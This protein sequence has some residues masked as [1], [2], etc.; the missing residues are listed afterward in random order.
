MEVIIFSRDSLGVA[1]IPPI[2]L[3]PYLKLLYKN[4]E[5]NGINIIDLNWR[6]SF[7]KLLFMRKKIS[8]V[9][10]HWIE[11]YFTSLNPLVTFFKI[12]VFIFQ[13]LLFKILK[14]KIMVT[15]HNV[16]PHERAFPKLVQVFFAWALKLSDGIIVHNYYAKRFVVEVYE[17]NAKKIFVIPHG[18]FLN[19]YPES[20]TPPKEAKAKLGISLD[21]FVLLFFGT[22]RPYKGINL[23][24][25]SFEEAVKKNPQLFLI[26]AGDCQDASLRTELTKFQVCFPENCMFKL[27]YVPDSEVSTLMK[28][29]NIGILPYQEIT[30]SGAA[31]LFISYGL[32]LIASNLPA[33]KEILKDGSC[34]FFNRNDPKSLEKTILIAARNTT[35]YN[36]SKEK[37]Q[38][39]AKLLGWQKIADSTIF[40]YYKLIKEKFAL[41]S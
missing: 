7:L 4:V 23:L 38:N 18:N 25:S 26:V 12:Y 33:I 24:L 31:L 13:F 17:T 35:L 10:L 8:V 30:S 20:I 32:P 27:D 37:I 14:L 15:L 39:S 16:V 40:A 19:Y 3:H 41:T 21:K 28:I 2:K 6:F 5:K 22:I 11:F 9:H 34:F 1:V 29:A 36:F